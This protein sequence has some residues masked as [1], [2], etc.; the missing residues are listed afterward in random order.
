MPKTSVKAHTRVQNGKKTKVRS[1]SRDITAKHAR[2]NLHLEKL[3][4]QKES[5][6]DKMK[7][8]R[9]EYDYDV[10]AA[11]NAEQGLPAPPRKEMPQS[12]KHKISECQSKV[13]FHNKVADKLRQK[14]Y[15]MLD[16]GAEKV[17][18]ALA[19]GK[20]SNVHTLIS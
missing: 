13:D 3:D 5:E 9:E 14:K 17:A 19:S 18:N 7:K 1:S 2:I 20:I 12:V 10:I 15:E 8:L 16:K 11:E 4:A 6:Y